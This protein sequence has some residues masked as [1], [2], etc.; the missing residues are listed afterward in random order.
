[1]GDITLSG[2][3]IVINYDEVT[4]IEWRDFFSGKTDH[5]G[6][7]DFVSKA[8]GLK[9]VEIHNMKRNDYRRLITALAKKSS[10]PL[11]DPN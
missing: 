2:K 5:D 1:M 11:I 10:E 4:M 9:I 7:D 3:E 8:T 6:D